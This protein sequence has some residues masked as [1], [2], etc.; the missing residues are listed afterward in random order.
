MGLQ[1]KCRDCAKERN[2]T[3]RTESFDSPETRKEYLDKKKKYNRSIKYYDNYFRK[4]F[5]ITYEQVK[6]MYDSQYGKC[7]NRACDKELVFYHDNEHGRA[8]PNRACVDHDHVTGRVRALLC[9][10]CNTIL[11]TIE[12]R[13]NIISGLM[14]YLAFF[15]SKLP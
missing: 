1:S 13:G 11:G 12:A 15:R 3:K 14:E 8:H 2:R 10:P 6:S 5:G 7:A 9:M 4:R